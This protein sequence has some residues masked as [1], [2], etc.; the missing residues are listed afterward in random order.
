MSK[1]KKSQEEKQKEKQLKKAKKEREA[2][3]RKIDRDAKKE[4]TT[5][6]VKA[7][8]NYYSFIYKIIS[9][10]ILIAFAIIILVKQ[11]HAVFTM[12]IV[13][14]GVT[15]FMAILRTIMLL[16]KKKD[17]DK[18]VRNVTLVISLIHFII[19]C[20]LIVAAIFY[21]K[22]LDNGDFEKFAKFNN[23]Y[24]PIFLASIL[25]S[26]SIGYFMNTVLF[27]VNSGKFNFWL[28]I[29]FITLAVV[30]LS[31]NN[32]DGKKIAITLA[33]IALICALFTGIDAG[34][35][36]FNYRNGKHPRKEKNESKKDEK[37]D[38]AG[39]DMPSDSNNEPLIDPNVINDK[40]DNDSAI[41]Q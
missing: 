34:V 36:Y 14:A 6:N 28:H 20:Y 2:A 23:D 8:F 12:L 10:V 22:Y 16:I 26:E 40:N 30:V 15:I 24:F 27:K 4:E 17:T 18:R 31:L 11:S 19:S 13:T 33:I 35:G 3:L 37:K 21:F 32:I 38:E 5:E 29:V 9:A 7:S 41:I 1:V 39:L 25:Y